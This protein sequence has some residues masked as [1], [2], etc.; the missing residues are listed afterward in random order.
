M[1]AD[2]PAN[3]RDAVYVLPQSA[4]TY[5]KRARSKLTQKIQKHFEACGIKTT[6]KR[7][8]G[9]RARVVVGFH[10]LRH[11]FVSMAREAG[12]PL[13][14]I[15][16]LVGHHSVSLTRHYT[17]VSEAASQNAIG[18]LPSLDSSALVPA[19]RAR[20]EILRNLIESMT[21]GNWREKKAAA[22]A[23]LAGTTN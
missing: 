16:G 6:E 11:A 14:V 12:A 3:E 18:L 7:E 15:K 21:A 5:L 1:L 17:H 13:A 9:S 22:L 23:M 20:D 10:S 19:G 4:H 2:V 8:V